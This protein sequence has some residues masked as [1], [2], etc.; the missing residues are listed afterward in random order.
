MRCHGEPKDILRSAIVFFQVSVKF[1]TAS[2][3]SISK[4]LVANSTAI[5]QA[6]EKTAKLLVA[7]E[8]FK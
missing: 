3:Q 7:Q 1:D 5:V 6:P 4:A 2:M 8:I